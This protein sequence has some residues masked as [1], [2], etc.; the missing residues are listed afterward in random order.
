MLGKVGF[1]GEGQVFEGFPTS[2]KSYLLRLHRWIRGDWQII[3][4][5]FTN[6]KIKNGNIIRN[7]LFFM[8]K[9][10]IFDSL[11]NS[12]LIP[13]LFILTFLITL[14]DFENRELLYAILIIEFFAFDYLTGLIELIIKFI[15]V[16][17]IKFLIKQD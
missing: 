1:A 17:K 15:H 3:N 13:D 6:I 8:D 2:V 10:K 11:M 14:L 9:V 16:K 4:W 7:P 12:I 5:L